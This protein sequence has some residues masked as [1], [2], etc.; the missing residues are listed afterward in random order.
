MEIPA[1][2]PS[3]DAEPGDFRHITMRESYRS[4]VFSVWKTMNAIPDAWLQL[5]DIE[6]PRHD[7][8]SLNARLE[9]VRL[10]EFQNIVLER[11]D[12]M[13]LENFFHGVFM[14]IIVQIAKLGWYGYMAREV[15][16]RAVPAAGMAIDEPPVLEMANELNINPPE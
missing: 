10:T 5:R 14:D 13:G 12:L 15:A 4:L 6:I 7:D 3:L 11:V 16:A 9:R 1:I 8:V 2:P